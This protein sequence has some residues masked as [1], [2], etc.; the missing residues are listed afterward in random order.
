MVQVG[1][2]TVRIG[3]GFVEDSASTRFPVDCH[4]FV[5]EDGSFICV[6]AEQLCCVREGLTTQAYAERS[7]ARIEAAALAAKT[8]FRLK[9]QTEAKKVVTTVMETYVN[10]HIGPS[11]IIVIAFFLVHGPMAYVI[12][13]QC[14]ANEY[15]K[16]LAD[17]LACVQSARLLG[18]G[19]TRMTRGSNVLT[20]V[21]A[22]GHAAFE[23]Y[24][25]PLFAVSTDRGGRL[26]LEHH[27]T[28]AWWGILTTREEPVDVGEKA[29]WALLEGKVFFHCFTDDERLEEA[30][31]MEIESL[32][33]PELCF[34]NKLSERPLDLYCYVSLDLNVPLPDLT[35]YE[36]SVCEHSADAF[37][38]L[39]IKPKTRMDFTFEMELRTVAVVD[40]NM[41]PFMLYLESLFLT[42]VSPSLS[43]GTDGAERISVEGIAAHGCDAMLVI[44]AVR[45]GESEYWLVVRWMFGGC[46]PLPSDLDRYTEQLLYGITVT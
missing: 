36:V 44:E 43:R 12:Q 30:A 24:V 22:D 1:D 39:F 14:L 4:Q 16:R 42:A 29:V 11:P 38:T 46:D 33:A 6:M 27:S 45:L 3:R 40:E 25:S 18:A 28:T 41:E 9:L 13:L 7:L 37:V 26:R 35:V 5:H 20:V 8:F 23:V 21:D 17:V 32:L 31:C 15:E 19:D 10:F 2:L 34:A